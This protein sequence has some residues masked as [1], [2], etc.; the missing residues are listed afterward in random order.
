MNTSTNEGSIAALVQAANKKKNESEGRKALA[1][2]QA[3]NNKSAEQ[4]TNNHTA[5]MRRNV[6]FNPKSL[7]RLD[8]IKSMDE[9]GMSA[10][11]QAALS[12]F[13]SAS[14]KDREAVYNA[15]KIKCKFDN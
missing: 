13:A 11:I 7:D 6:Y 8:D 15:L 9:V 2:T 10:A 1:D 5:G 3:K 14:D 4:V 12:M